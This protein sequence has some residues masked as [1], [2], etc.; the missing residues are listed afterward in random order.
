M[1]DVPFTILFMN[2]K[3]SYD[4]QNVRPN[5]VNPVILSKLF[6]FQLL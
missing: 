2:I 6:L 5:P 1:R 3:L 4:L